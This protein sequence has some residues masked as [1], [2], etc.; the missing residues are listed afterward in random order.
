MEDSKEIKWCNFTPYQKWSLIDASTNGKFTGVSAWNAKNFEGN[1]YF[2]HYPF[3]SWWIKLQ[4]WYF[5][6]HLIL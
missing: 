5:L 2:I 1:E 3:L 6:P 4:S